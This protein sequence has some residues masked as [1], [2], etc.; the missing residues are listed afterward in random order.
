MIMRCLDALAASD[1]PACEIIVVDDCS[2]D[3]SAEV[4]RQRG[5][6]VLKMTHQSGPAAAR[7]FGSQQA[8]G[9]VLLFV[10][11]DVV[12][13]SNAIRRVA[14]SFENNPGLGAVFGS[15]DDEPAEKNFLSQY[16][17]MFHHFVHQQA[18]PEAETFWAGCG[19]I[20]RRI[21][22]AVG[23]FD[24]DLY[25]RPAIEDI[26]L[27][28]RMRRQGHRILLDKDLQCKHLKEWRLGS[29]LRADVLSRAVPW[30]R[31]ILERNQ[32][33]NDLNLKT[34]EKVSA[35]VAGLLVAA[36][37]ASLFSLKFLFVAAALAPAIVLLNLDFYR[38]FLRRKGIGFVAGTY[39]MHVFYYLYS[40][41]TFALCWLQ[42]QFR[43]SVKANPMNSVGDGQN[44]KGED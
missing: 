42:H 19:A 6:A 40:T 20:D 31:L 3:N 24:G 21:F 34:S 36:L 28:Y 5:A 4:S 38:F 30:T 44:L 16:K 2:T 7:N 27:G 11:A 26:E 15:Y 41:A 10:D 8:R 23:G 35:V 25:R 43:Q 39:F 33:V 29:L 9:D 32:Q 14:E 1:Y 12:V 18:N 22:A 37:F 13:H 17:N